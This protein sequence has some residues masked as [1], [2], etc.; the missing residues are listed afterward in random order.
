MELQSCRKGKGK[1]K[2]KKKKKD[3]RWATRDNASDCTASSIPLKA[4]L[5]VTSSIFISSSVLTLTLSLSLSL[6]SLGTQDL[7]IEVF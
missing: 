4:F 7:V 5:T 2:K 3:R 1:K 6:S